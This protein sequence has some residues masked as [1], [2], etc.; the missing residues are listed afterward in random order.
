MTATIKKRKAND[1]EWYFDGHD[2]AMFFDQIEVGHTVWLNLGRVGAW[3]CKVLEKIDDTR[4]RLLLV[5]A[6]FDDP[7]CNVFA[8]PVWLI[9]NADGKVLDSSQDRH[10][11]E[12]FDEDDT[13]EVNRLLAESAIEESEE[14]DE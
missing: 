7:C 6:T 4:G 11:I 14:D 12:K 2:D 1:V 10:F 8:N 13:A 9:V 3:P 5:E